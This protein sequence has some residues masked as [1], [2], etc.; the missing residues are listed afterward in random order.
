M[1]RIVAV[2]LLL[3]MCC[4]LAGCYDAK[5]V[6]DLAYV[7]AIGVDKGQTNLLKVTMQLAVP[8]ALGG[9]GGGGGGGAGKPYS[10]ITL[11]APTLTSSLNMANNFMSRRLELSHAEVAVFSEELAKSGTIDEYLRG[12][13][14]SREFRPTINIAVCK[15]P[16]EEYLRGIKPVLD[17]DPAKYYELTFSNY[18]YTGLSIRSQLTEFYADM[19]SSCVQA[20]AVLAGVNKPKPPEGGQSGGSAQGEQSGGSDKSDQSGDSGGS[21]KDGQSGGSA[22][23]SQAGGPQQAAMPEESTS[24]SKGRP[25]PFE[26][27]YE[28]GSIPRTGDVKGEIEGLAVFDGNRMVGEMDGEA[29]TDYLLVNG[30]FHNA[31]K[32]FG[33]PQVKGAYV[34][35]NVSQKSKPVRRVKIVD[36]KPQISV[37]IALDADIQ[38]IQSGYNYEDVKKLPILEQAVETQFHDEIASFLSQTAST[39]HSDIC[40]FGDNAKSLFLTWKDWEGYHWLQQ[41]KNAAFDV[42]VRVRIRRPGLILSSEPIQSSGGANMQ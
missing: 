29:A 25:Q 8:S 10:I 30:D 14:R 35:L 34:V 24:K 15:S 19:E 9:G 33:D 11:E 37:Q 6:D 22:Q 32:T 7:L 13:I 41:Y 18:R 38:T 20:V 36:G 39:F 12:M 17:L 1:R 40:G 5:E 16:A 3:V 26:G 2:M 23:G 4:G 42:N 28:A 21:A 31:Y 27:D